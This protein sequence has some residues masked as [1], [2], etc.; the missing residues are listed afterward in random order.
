MTTGR[1][2]QVTIVIVVGWV[3]PPAD[4][5]FRLSTRDSRLGDVTVLF[6]PTLGFTLELNGLRPI[7]D[8]VACAPNMASVNCRY[9]ILLPSLFEF[10]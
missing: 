4:I 6:T 10:P 3:A 7:A 8:L 2:N 9:P 1:I 5:T